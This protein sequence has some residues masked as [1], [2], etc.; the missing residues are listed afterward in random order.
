[1]PLESIPHSQEEDEEEIHITRWR[2]LRKITDP[3]A[4]PKSDPKGEG[5]TVSPE[6]SQK[7][8]K[9]PQA[10][11]ALKKKRKLLSVEASK[12]ANVYLLRCLSHLENKFWLTIML[13]ASNQLWL[14]SCYPFASSRKT[15]PLFNCWVLSSSPSARGG[16]GSFGDRWRTSSHLGGSIFHINRRGVAGQSLARGGGCKPLEAGERKRKAST[17]YRSRMPPMMENKMKIS[18]KSILSRMKK[19]KRKKKFRLLLPNQ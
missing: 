6:K 13:S 12:K 18:P 16:G 5:I 10:G 7:K 11:E 9:E 4:T 15:I 2:R 1:M 8:S 19:K 3:V 14:S 17:I